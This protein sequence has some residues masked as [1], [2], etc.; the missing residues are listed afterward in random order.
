MG[1][2]VKAVA[3]CLAAFLCAVSAISV[4]LP[5]PVAVS[6]DRDFLLNN[7]DQDDSI[8]PQKESV[9]P[10]EDSALISN[11]TD[12]HSTSLQNTG[13][14]LTLIIM[15]HAKT[16]PRMYPRKKYDFGRRLVR[17]GMEESSRVGSKLAGMGLHPDL[18]LVSPSERTKETWDFA[19]KSFDSHIPV[20]YVDALYHSDLGVFLDVLRSETSGRYAS[21]IIVVGHKPSVNDVIFWLTNQ[22]VVF[23]TGAA[24]VLSFKSARNNDVNNMEDSWSSA[25]KS[26]HSWNLVKLVEST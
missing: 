19:S 3:F 26:A 11:D 21:T 5:V 8:L 18:A 6:E 12:E 20:R 14:G 23:K 17:R 4:T 10:V 25:F 7:G 13:N 9:A 2:S 24:A 16:E 22:E 15:R 1:L